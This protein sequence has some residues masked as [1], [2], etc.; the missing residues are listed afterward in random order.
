MHCKLILWPFKFIMSFA[1]SNKVLICFMALLLINKS[2]SFFTTSISINILST[3][4]NN[5]RVIHFKH[6]TSKPSPNLN[7]DWLG[8]CFTYFNS[9]GDSVF[10]NSSIHIMSA[11]VY[12]QLI[13]N[14][15]LPKF[16]RI[17]L[18]WNESGLKLKS[19]TWTSMWTSS[20][21]VCEDNP[22]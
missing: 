19:I 16:S 5:G 12:E 9:S 8:T 2:I 7:T 21:F 15:L 20:E 1:T 4:I 14:R 10:K 3:P 17:S 6:L 13:F 22:L 11:I 18:D